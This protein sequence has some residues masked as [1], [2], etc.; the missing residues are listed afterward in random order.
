[1]KRTYQ[2]LI[3]RAFGRVTVTG[4][5]RR[6]GERLMLPCRCSCG[7]ERFVRACEIGVRDAGPCPSCPRTPGQVQKPGQWNH[8]LHRVYQHMIDRCT[9]TAAHNYR[10]YGATGVRVCDRW[11][12]SFDGFVEDVGPRPPDT[13]L[14][15]FPD[16]NGNYEPGNVRWATR[17]EQA[18]NARNNLL[19]TIGGRT[20][21]LKEWARE[22]SV[23]YRALYHQVVALGVEISDAAAKVRATPPAGLQSHHARPRIA[24][25]LREGARVVDIMAATGASHGLV[26]KVRREL[27]GRHG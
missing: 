11:L 6:I 23:D 14:D 9:N 24:R 22:F 3:G 17:L 2:D 12:A 8:P 5:A 26:Y 4:D 10:W 15:R 20:L 18:N 7:A 21:T 19:F 13:T 27:T 25:M 16:K 1:M